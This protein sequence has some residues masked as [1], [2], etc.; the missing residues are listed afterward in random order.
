MFRYDYSVT[1]EK[2]LQ[3]ACD[4]V[5]EMLRRERQRQGL[6][7]TSLATRAGLSQQSVSYV[8]RCMRTPNLDTL[9][10]ITDAL[11]IELSP[12]IAKALK[13]TKSDRP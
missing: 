2:M 8:E 13:A 7:M 10:R 3:L 1:K 6:S 5:A 4:K 12:L 11:G 9:I